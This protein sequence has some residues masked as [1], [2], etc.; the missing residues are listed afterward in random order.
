VVRP[1]PSDPPR[2]LGVVGT[3]ARNTYIAARAR[4]LTRAAAVVAAG[5]VTRAPKGAAYQAE[6]R[7]PTLPAAIEAA[8]EALQSEV[9]GGLAAKVKRLLNLAE[10]LLG[11][12]EAAL[13]EG[14][15]TRSL[16]DASQALTGLLRELR[17]MGGLDSGGAP[18]TVQVGVQVREDQRRV[19][20]ELGGILARHC[21]DLAGVILE[22]LCRQLEGGAP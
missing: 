16:R 21:P 20:Q 15:D 6:L 1:L 17:G 4:G 19:A 22:D 11:R 5:I 3:P 13:D 8:R 9:V 14:G 10:R 18:V 2:A 7:D 12:V